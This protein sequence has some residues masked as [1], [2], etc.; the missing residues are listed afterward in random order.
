[1]KNKNEKPLLSIESEK[2]TL[3][4]QS[5]EMSVDKKISSES[6]SWLLSTADL[7]EDELA[8]QERSLAA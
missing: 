8:C 5:D 6:Y 3:G 7:G 2:D 1:M 4:D